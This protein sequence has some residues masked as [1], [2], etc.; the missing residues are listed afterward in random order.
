MTTTEISI[1]H[2]NMDDNW[3]LTQ[4]IREEVFIVEQACEPDEEWDQYDKCSR[5]LVAMLDGT[6][7]VATARWRSTIYEGI[8]VA[9]LERI[10]VPDAF[11]RRGFGRTI[12]EALMA[13]ARKAGFDCFIL[14]A[15]PYLIEFYKSL[16]FSEV[17]D[18]FVEAGIP[19]KLLV[20]I[21]CRS[22]GADA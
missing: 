2:V 22:I 10:A 1:V 14:H 15:Q 9:K 18:E 12:V 13:D 16:G 7:P 8:S 20:S 11:R 21:A 6:T 5:H 17:G 4:R 3:E 19:H